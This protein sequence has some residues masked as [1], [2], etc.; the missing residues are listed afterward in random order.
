MKLSPR[1]AKSN[2]FEKLNSDNHHTE[3]YWI[4]LNEDSVCIAKQTAGEGCEQ[5]IIIEKIQFNR[6]ID[7]Y[8]REQVV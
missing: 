1:K 3:N 8:N 5:E 2:Q 6:L 7:W 4:L